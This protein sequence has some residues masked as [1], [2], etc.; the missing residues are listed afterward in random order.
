M[1]CA[2]MVLSQER[3]E[4]LGLNRKEMEQTGFRWW[5]II[6]IRASYVISK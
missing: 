2:S 3:M 5:E 4:L 1:R 6:I